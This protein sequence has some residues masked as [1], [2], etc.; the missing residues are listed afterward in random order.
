MKPLETLHYEKKGEIALITLHRPD[1][2]HAIDVVMASELPTVW[3]DIKADDAIR[4]VVMTASGE[5]AFCTGFD[6]G[7]LAAGKV[8]ADAPGPL[9]ELRFTAIHNRCYK[10]V[11]TAING[12][13]CGGGLHFLADT[14]IAICSENATFFDSHVN[15]GT[16]AGLEPIGLSR[17]I[18]IGPVL[19]MALLGRKDR[20]NALQGLEMGLVSEV[21]AQHELRPRALELAALIAENSPTALMRTKR[22]LWESLDVGLTEAQARAWPLLRRH[23]AHPDTLEG[24]RAFAEKRGARWAPPEDDA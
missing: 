24:A 3:A 10:P 17:R 5:R 12:M 21:L 1:R 4:V 11:I 7:D 20:I 2:L 6:M 9:A 8:S 22:I 23:I 15:V 13:V 14:D 18:S 16:V 19:R